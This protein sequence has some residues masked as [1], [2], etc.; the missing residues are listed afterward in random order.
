MTAVLRGSLLALVAV[1]LL[2]CGKPSPRQTRELQL[3]GKAVELKPASFDALAAQVNQLCEVAGF[4]SANVNVQAVGRSREQ[5]SS[6][7]AGGQRV[8]SS[9]RTSM[10]LNDRLE[11]LIQQYNQM[12]PSK[13]VDPRVHTQIV[14]RLRAE[15]SGWQLAVLYESD[16]GPQAS[17]SKFE[18]Y[19]YQKVTLGPTKIECV[20]EVAEG[21]SSRR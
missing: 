16:T 15:R 21:K 6:V 1:A 7:E 9:Q 19:A 20:T 14:E 17:L 18:Q 12:V 11:G 3:D 5:L 10:V 8:V 2:G 13:P 4:L